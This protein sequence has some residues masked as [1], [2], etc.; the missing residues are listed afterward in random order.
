MLCLF[1]G[2]VIALLSYANRFSVNP[3]GISYL[4][5]ADQMLKGDLAVFVHPYW[6]PLYPC[7][8]AFALRVFSPTPSGEIL[9]VHLVNCFIG[10][11]ALASFTFFLS[12]WSGLRGMDPKDED[13]MTA[14]RLQTGFAYVLFLWGTS[15]MIGLAFVTPDLCVAA[16]VYLI[17]GLCCRL[18]SPHG[19]W[20]TSI[21]LGIALSLAAFSKAAMLPLGV[22]LLALLA[23]PQ[24]FAP[25][26]RL[27]LAIAV[28][29]FVIAVG[30][31]VFLMSRNQ[32]RLT[33]GD[34]GRLNYAWL[35]LREVP[36]HAGW[37]GHTSGTGNPVHPP[38]VLMV[39]PT[40]LE[41]KGTVPGT[42]PL[43]YNPAYFHEG[44]QVRFD[45]RK[46]MICLMHS[47]KTFLL[48]HGRLLSPLLAGIAVLCTFAFLR[49]VRVDLSREWLILWPLAAF[50]MYA[51]VTVDA[52]YISPF[53]VLFWIAVYDTVSPGLLAS[54]P[55]AYD[56]VISV[57]AI[58][59]LLFQLLYLGSAVTASRREPKTPTQLV[60]ARELVRLGL[61]PGDEIATVGYPLAVYYARLARLR[62][63]A[64]IG[65]RG[66]GEGYEYDTAQ[67]WGLSESK[68][69]A[70]KEELR[71]IGAKAIVSPDEC[72]VT[73][74]NGWQSI[75]DT[76]YCVQLLD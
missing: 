23:I 67:F 12:Q 6:S 31:Y 42:Y 3:D 47:A 27:S 20:G 14:F 43:W 62:V 76:E 73:A 66:E 60:V 65:F 74:H 44:L 59:M 26:R 56:A 10:L 1:C 30:P 72:K 58:C 22:A 25:P 7:L 61:R 18:A 49:R 71:R 68:F 70:L 75:R 53:L 37:I 36:L 8:L 9:V 69:N 46:Q 32:H 33:F 38:R 13:S 29:I 39:G 24:L 55:S 17:A 64:N 51:L 52:R 19:G 11:S 35:V 15:E 5:M 45:A 57:T 40:V 16:L 41:F 34:A 21:A 50:S 63:I 2:L 4:D 28:L 48:A 54:A